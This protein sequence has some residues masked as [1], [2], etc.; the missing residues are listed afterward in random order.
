MSMLPSY[1]F[2]F[3]KIYKKSPFYR[4]K[5]KFFMVYRYQL[6]STIFKKIN[7][8]YDNPKAR[9]SFGE[10]SRKIAENLNYRFIAKRFIKS[11]DFKEKL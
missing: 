3:N 7:F 4:K 8:F 11:I 2:S 9:K 6:T 1:N 5:L 10:E